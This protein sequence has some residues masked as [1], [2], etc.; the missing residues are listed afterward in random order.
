ML[1]WIQHPR[2]SSRRFL[3]LDRDGVINV[4]SSKYIKN[5]DEVRFYPDA[6]DALRFLRQQSVQ[7]ILISNQSVVNRGF[8]SIETLWDIH[9][10]MLDRIRRAGGDVLAAFYCPHRPDEACA[11][12]KPSPRMILYAAGI[13][14]IETAETSLIGDRSSDILAGGDSGCRTVLLER[15]DSEHPPEGAWAG[16]QPDERYP[17][18]LEAVTALWKQGKLS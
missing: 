2:P 9:D 3:F 16:R 4:D 13:F 12:R 1:V 10:R 5:W 18:L 11:C 17:S 15:P 7:G 6:L 8:T 14:S